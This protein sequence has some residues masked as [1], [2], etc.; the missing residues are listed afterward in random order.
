MPFFTGID[1]RA[2]SRKKIDAYQFL[3]CLRD[4]NDVV[5]KGKGVSAGEE[6][7]PFTLTKFILDVQEGCP[8]KTYVDVG[9]W[10]QRV[11]PISNAFEGAVC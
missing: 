5:Q 7:L 4:K 8:P 9:Y 6:A 1:S 2:N 10:R 3:V 11:S